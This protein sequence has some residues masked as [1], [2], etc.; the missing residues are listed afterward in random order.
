MEAIIT[1]IENNLKRLEELET[2][3]IEQLDHFILNLWATLSIVNEK[4]NDSL[5][6]KRQ[7]EILNTFDWTVENIN[8]LLHLNEKLINCFEKLRDVPTA[9]INTLT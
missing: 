6:I 1:Q 2:S 5:F 4:C 3:T 7:R 9:A 8:K